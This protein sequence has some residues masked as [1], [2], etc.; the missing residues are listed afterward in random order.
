MEKRDILTR[1]SFLSLPSSNSP[2]SLSMSPFLP[3]AFSLS[4]FYLSGYYSPSFLFSVPSI[5]LSFF[6]PAF[7][8]SLFLLVFSFL[9]PFLHLSLSLFSLSPLPLLPFKYSLSHLLVFSLPLLWFFSTTSFSFSLHLP[10]SRRFWIIVS[11][12]FPSRLLSPSLSANVVCFV[13]DALNSD[14]QCSKNT[15]YVCTCKSRGERRRGRKT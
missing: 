8:P 5:L 10:H 13:V 1:F 14:F 7:S 15:S 12:F 2:F 3:L 11:L 6:P 4:L 9:P